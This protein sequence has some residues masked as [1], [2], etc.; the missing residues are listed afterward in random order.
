LTPAGR[1]KR[2]NRAGCFRLVGALSVSVGS[3]TNTPGTGRWGLT[4]IRHTLLPS[5]KR[6]AGWPATPDIY[7]HTGPLSVMLI[8]WASTRKF[9][10]TPLMVTEPPAELMPLLRVAV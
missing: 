10:I 9:F 3:S 8:G 1:D 5:G 6:V 2:I 4:E 7:C